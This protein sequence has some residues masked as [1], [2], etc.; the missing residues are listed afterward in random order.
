VVSF[1][2][3][4]APRRGWVGV[5]L[6]LIASVALMLV[7]PKEDWRPSRLS[8]FLTFL[9]VAPVAGVYS[10]RARRLAPDRVIALAAFAGSFIVAAF[11]LLMVVGIIGSFFVS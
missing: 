3:Q 2:T 9:F 8:M 11:W 7:D 1:F 6:L 4:R 10:F 5:L